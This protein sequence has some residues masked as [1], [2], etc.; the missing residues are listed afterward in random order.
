M[1]KILQK[2][3]VFLRIIQIVSNEERKKQNLKHLGKGFSKA[4]R[5]NPFNP[6]SWGLYFSAIPVYLLLIIIV[7]IVRTLAKIENPFRWN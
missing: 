4:Y 5:L 3:A 1:R 2:I 7:S 6:I